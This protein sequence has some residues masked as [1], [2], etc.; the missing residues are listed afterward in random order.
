[1]HVE[2]W[3]GRDESLDLRISQEVE[4]IPGCAVTV[5][6]LS[7]LFTAPLPPGPGSTV[8]NIVGW[9]PLE[10]TARSGVWWFLGALKGESVFSS[11]SAM[12]LFSPFSSC[13][14]FC[15]SS[16]LSWSGS[17]CQVGATRLRWMSM[18][19]CSSLILLMLE[20]ER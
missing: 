14:D 1:M 11:L 7:S 8:R 5:S 18:A 13:F 20:R 10:K 4:I 17:G 6:T 12:L 16:E 3:A 15:F 9:T 2:T 19:P